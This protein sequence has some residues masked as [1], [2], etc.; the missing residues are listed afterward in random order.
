MRHRFAVAL[1]AAS[2]AASMASAAPAAKF[3]STPKPL[4]RTIPATAAWH[5]APPAGSP[6]LKQWNGSFTDHLGQTVTYTMVG[7]DPATTNTTST[8]PV[9]VIPVKF[10]YGK[11]TGKM[12]FDPLAVTQSN[13]RSLMSNFLNSPLFKNNVKFVQGG[14]NVGTTQY[15]D[16]FQRANFWKYVRANRNYHVLL[17]KPTVLPEQTINVTNPALGLVMD[18]PFGTGKCSDNRSNCVGT[19]EIDLFDRKVQTWL[20]NF[21]EITPRSLPLF[22]SYN[23]Y[24]TEGTSEQVCCIGGYHSAT[25]GHPTGQTYSYATY[26]DLPGVFSQDVSAWSHEIGEWMDDPF[27]DND[28]NCADNSIMEDG[29]PLENNANSGAWPYTVNGF[30]YNL[31][32][33]V[34][35][36]YFGAPR[37]TS[38]HQWL[39]FQNDE[40]NVCP[41]Q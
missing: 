16:A 8:I 38:L 26:V 19:Y 18:N 40:Q 41:G 7:T 35:I 15:I 39:S 23:I 27:T 3:V 24:L 4:F 11:L 37:N 2:V 34:F 22:I 12:Q 6:R 29:D 20:A 9:Y 14:T 10:T 17:G 33:L 28:V 1:L 30:T 13:G 25:A 36:G 21:P 5:V 32:S 31:Q